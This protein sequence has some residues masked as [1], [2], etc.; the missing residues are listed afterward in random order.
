MRNL[1]GVVQHQL[2]ICNLIS[3]HVHKVLLDGLEKDKF[4][5]YNTF[6]LF[7]NG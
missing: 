4:A 5:W 2:L 1:V 6:F 3:V 7:P